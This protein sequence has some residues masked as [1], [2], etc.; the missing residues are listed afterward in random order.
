M[1]TL[2][3][4]VDNLKSVELGNAILDTVIK[5]SEC[6][7]AITS[8]GVS[9]SVDWDTER[10]VILDALTLVQEQN[11]SDEKSKTRTPT[12]QNSRRNQA[13]RKTNGLGHRTRRQP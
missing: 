10:A 11:S 5:L 12:R 8:G 9:E 1:Y 13:R 7:G 2:E 6:Y 3:V 4:R